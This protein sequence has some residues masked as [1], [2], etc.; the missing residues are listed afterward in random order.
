MRWL[1]R[2][3]LFGIGVVAVRYGFGSGFLPGSVA[4]CLSVVA[5][6]LLLKWQG[7]YALLREAAEWAD[8]R[9]KTADIEKR[10]QCESE[11]RRIFRKLRDR[12]GMPTEDIRQQIMQM[13]QARR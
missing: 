3:V 1:V 4:L 8:K 11:L 6:W 5:F 10:I 2:V 9:H 13:R 12:Y 7:R